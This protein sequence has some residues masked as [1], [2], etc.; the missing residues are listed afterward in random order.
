MTLGRHTDPTPSEIE[1]VGHSLNALG[2]AGWLV[3]SDGVYHSA[4]R[5]SLLMVRLITA[6][7]GNWAETECLWHEIRASLR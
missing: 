6:T 5:M 4:E 7:D 2:T 1:Q 3:V